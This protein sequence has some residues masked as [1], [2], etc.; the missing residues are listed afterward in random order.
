[1]DRLVHESWRDEGKEE[2]EEEEEGAL[3]D[4]TPH[5][6]TVTCSPGTDTESPVGGKHAHL[7]LI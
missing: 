3:V 7:E 2:E 6:Y 4:V 5:P 1:M